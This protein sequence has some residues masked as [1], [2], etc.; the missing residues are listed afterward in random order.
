[1]LWEGAEA[2][3]SINYSLV[4][5]G[6]FPKGIRGCNRRE[7]TRVGLSGAHGLIP[8]QTQLGDTTGSDIGSVT[9]GAKVGDEPNKGGADGID[10]TIE[11]DLSVWIDDGILL[12]GVTD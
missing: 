4:G 11:G 3:I 7:S 10:H 1:M 2:N 6:I 12:D 5:A 8:G 9:I